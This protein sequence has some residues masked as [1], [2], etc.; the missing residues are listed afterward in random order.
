LPEKGDTI[1]VTDKFCQSHGRELLITNVLWNTAY[2]IHAGG[3]VY[4]LSAIELVRLHD[5]P[6][7]EEPAPVKPKTIARGYEGDLNGKHVTVHNPGTFYDGFEGTVIQHTFD[8]G[9]CRVLFDDEEPTPLD[10]LHVFDANELVVSPK[11]S[12]AKSE[13]AP[14]DHVADAGK[15]VEPKFH[16]LSGGWIPEIGLRVVCTGPDEDIKGWHGEIFAFTDSRIDV[17]MDRDGCEY[18][19][20]Q[21]NLCLESEWGEDD[22]AGAGKVIKE[23]EKEPFKVGQR[24]KYTGNARGYKDRS[25]EVKGESPGSVQV[26]FDDS[27]FAIGVDPDYLIPEPPLEPQSL[28]SDSVNHPRHYNT[29]PS[30]IECIEIARHYGFNIGNVIKYVWRCEEKGAPIE[31][32][33]KAAWYLNDEIQ[34]REKASGQG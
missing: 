22:V 6:T 8:D 12:K 27:S 18:T 1:R 16:P 31:D 3:G 29:H 14:A 28:A 7:P 26:L 34:R 32:L 10:M 13:P 20:D 19:I 11:L 17:L 33:K 9:K 5:D 24:V 30:G 23:A 15:K 21:E 25:G 4:D 2:P